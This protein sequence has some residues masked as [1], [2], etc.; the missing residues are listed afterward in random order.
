MRIEIL[1]FMLMVAIGCTSEPS[2]RPLLK[3]KSE[4]IDKSVSQPP[5][6]AV[7]MRCQQVGELTKVYQQISLSFDGIDS[8]EAI[9][10]TAPAII[11]LCA[12]VKSI[13]KQDEEFPKMTESEQLELNEVFANGLGASV[14]TALS[15][16]AQS[17]VSAFQRVP[18]VER[19]AVVR[20]EFVSVSQSIK[21]HLAGLIEQR[22]E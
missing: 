5:I 18:D 12:E 10:D 8:V 13:L 1:F 17:A 11:E 6:S 9:D 3:P 21:S 4:S 14:D 7:T 20:A 15:K 22:Y 16:L 2:T 19:W